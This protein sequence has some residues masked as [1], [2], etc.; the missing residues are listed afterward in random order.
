MKRV[1]EMAARRLHRP[2]SN[3]YPHLVTPRSIARAAGAKSIDALWERQE[4]APF[5]VAPSKRAEWPRAFR[6]RY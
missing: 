5:F 3:V 6:E 1:G 4:R 2:W